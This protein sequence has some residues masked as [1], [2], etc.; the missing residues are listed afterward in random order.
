MVMATNKNS[1]IA[2][3]QCGFALVMFIAVIVVIVAVTAAGFLVL[4][5]RTNNNSSSVDTSNPTLFV[6]KSF[7]DLSKIFSISKFRSL[8][9]HDF[10][11]GGETCRSMK[12]Y[13]APQRTQAGMELVSKNNGIPPKPDGTNDID[14]FSP[15]DGKIT[16]IE[17]ERF[18][19]GEQIYL[20]PDAAS[21]YTVRIFHVFKTD[22][23]KVGSKVT[24]GQKIGVISSYS[25][26]DISVEGDGKF[27]SVF[28]VMTDDVFAEYLARGA[29][30]RDD[31]IISREYRDAHPVSCNQEKNSDQKFYLPDDYD[32]SSDEVHLSGYK[33]PIDPN[34][35][36]MN[37]W[38]G[39]Q[40]S[41]ETQQTSNTN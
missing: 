36:K 15:F 34:A 40:N 21:S 22:D 24:A 1:S 16:R 10:S 32:Q 13:F 7:V 33:N 2:K 8:Q 35:P 30:K 11:M 12:H 19:V 27:I 9:G 26:T 18:P 41:P 37:E 39:T 14:I 3:K 20:V 29:T 4:K 28:E 38:H 23:I 31:F 6:T 25:D 5:K 17:A